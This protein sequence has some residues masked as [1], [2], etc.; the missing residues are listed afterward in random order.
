M[1]PKIELAAHLFSPFGEAGRV[2]AVTGVWDCF[3][4]VVTNA[5]TQ[6]ITGVIIRSVSC[7]TA[8]QTIITCELSCVFECVNK[9]AR[10]Y[11]HVYCARANNKE[12]FMHEL[13]I[14]ERVEPV[15]PLA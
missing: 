13:V 3:E 5:L 7:P 1:L 12:R 6:V 8:V 2:G 15:L 14:S 9:D 4:T 10:R 11:Q